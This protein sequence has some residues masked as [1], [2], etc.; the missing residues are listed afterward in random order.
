MGQETMTAE[1][2]W[3]ALL[4]GNRRYVAGTLAHPHQSP[5]RRDEVVAGQHPFAIV[6]SCSDSRVPVEVLFDQGIGD[7]FVVRTAGNIVDDVALGSIEYAAKHLHVPLLVILGHQKC[8]AIAATAGGGEAPGHIASIVQILRPIV[9]GVRGQPGDVVENA[10]H[11]N[12][13]HLVAQLRSSQPILSHLV[14]EG[15]LK[16]VGAYYSLETGAVSLVE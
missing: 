16:V 9:E 1:A 10:V 13:R 7:I 11:A 15:R 2:A 3:Q 4:E 14:H 6:L 5:Q 12:V 8:G